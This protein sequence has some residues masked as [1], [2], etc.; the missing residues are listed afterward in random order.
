M[1]LYIANLDHP[2][3]NIVRNWQFSFYYLT[4]AKPLFREK[5]ANQLN[6]L[7]KEHKNEATRTVRRTRNS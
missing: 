1:K 2:A 6:L 7:I 4:M 5:L 3:S